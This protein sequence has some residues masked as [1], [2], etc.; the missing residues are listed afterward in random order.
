MKLIHVLGAAL[1]SCAALMSMGANAQ[2]QVP[3]DCRWQVISDFTSTSFR[4]VKEQCVDNNSTAWFAERR[5]KV[6]TTGERSNCDMTLY[7]ATV[8]NGTCLE[9]VLI[10]TVGACLSG[11]SVGQGC[12]FYRTR[13][14]WH[15]TPAPIGSD[16]INNV[17]CG[18]PSCPVIATNLGFT[19]DCKPK[20]ATQ[21]FDNPLF[22]YTCR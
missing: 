6:S 12:Q 14:G 13:H 10:R 5:F 18:D 2:Q 8:N 22:G 21:S 19:S 11:K 4:E 7:G 1:M 20:S 9:P 16:F 3:A 15:K 17:A